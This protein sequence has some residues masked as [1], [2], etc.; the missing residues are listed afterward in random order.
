M[1]LKNSFTVQIGLLHSQPLMNCHLH[2]LIV[3]EMG[4]GRLLN[5]S[6]VAQTN[7]K[8]SGVQVCKI[9][10]YTNTEV[11]GYGPLTY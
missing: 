3:V 5:V 10:C 8:R 1:G 2:F 7:M 4:N 11:T 6:S 9:K